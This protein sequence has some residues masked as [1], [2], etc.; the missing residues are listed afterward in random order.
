MKTLNKH[1]TDQ[2]SYAGAITGQHAI[3]YG[4]AGQDL[5][6]TVASRHLFTTTFRATVGAT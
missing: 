5:N 2:F 3:E 1:N 6:P 4:L